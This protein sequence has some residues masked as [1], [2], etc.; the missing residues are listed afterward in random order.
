MLVSVVSGLQV[1]LLKEGRKLVVESHCDQQS[2]LL[3][4]HDKGSETLR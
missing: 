3:Q 2:Q 1:Q 4:Q